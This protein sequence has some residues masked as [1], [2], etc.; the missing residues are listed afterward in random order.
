MNT[1]ESLSQAR[2]AITVRRVYG[3]PYQ[4]EGVTVIPAA[5]VM[6]G[7]GG[8]SD[9]QGNGGA[10]FGMR[11]RPAGAWV[12]KDGDVR[13][14]PAINADRM[15]FMGQLIAIVALLTIRS[16][17]KTIAKARRS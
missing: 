17:V 11:A 6:G 10:G 14:R 5:N 13:W 15:I 7:G 12:I 9:Q 8:G 4:E 3:D 16:I 1:L 2:E